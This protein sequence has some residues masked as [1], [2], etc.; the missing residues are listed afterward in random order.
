MLRV[1]IAIPSRGP[2]DKLAA[3]LESLGRQSQPPD[4]ILVGLDG[5]DDD[6]AQGVADRA[7]RSIAKRLSVLAFER[8]GYIPIRGALFAR[9]PGDLL[10]S[11]NDD[12][13]ADAGLV[14]AH[15]K[16]HAA[17]DESVV[18]CGRSRWK[19][20]EAPTLFDR[21]VERSPLIFF[22]P[23]LARDAGGV[24]SHRYCYGLNFSARAE[25]IREVGGC[26]GPAFGY[27]YD[28][29]EL[30]FRLERRLGARVVDG[31]DAIVVHDHRYTPDSVM[32]REYELG[33]SALAYANLNPDFARDLF[34]REITSEHELQYA[35]AYLERER[36]DALR[37]E[38][39]FIELAAMPAETW[40]DPPRAWHLL[41]EHWLVLKRYLWRWGLC[42]AA[43]E[44]APRWQ[45][46]AGAD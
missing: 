4:E 11:L 24:L 16:R 42:D 31:E 34:R 2:S 14:E 39:S 45:R 5:G 7:P 32:R 17:S 28:D 36:R 9:A 19:P 8:Q 3:C 37:V 35:R 29:T 44:I 10:I 20:V 38:R 30:A 18:V 46:L 33:R 25:A 21:L 43:D 26:V 1:S 40:G 15:A 22:D 23:E 13:I 41:A 12:V 27:G 6:D